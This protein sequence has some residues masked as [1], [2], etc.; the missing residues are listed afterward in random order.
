MCVHVYTPKGTKWLPRDQLI[1]LSALQ[2]IGDLAL[3]TADI[4][5]LPNECYSHDRLLTRQLRINPCVV[6]LFELNGSCL[7]E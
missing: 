4:L 2:A 1:G 7:L 6:S 3:T 5:N